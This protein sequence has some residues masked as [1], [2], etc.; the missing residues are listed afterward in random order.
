[1][2]FFSPLSLSPP[3]LS[4][5]I[6]NSPRR[7][8]RRVLHGLLSN[9]NMRIPT[10]KKFGDPPTPRTMTYLGGQGGYFE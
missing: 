1:M 4:G 8:C 10:P 9:T 7:D 5:L 3:S 2:A 6:A